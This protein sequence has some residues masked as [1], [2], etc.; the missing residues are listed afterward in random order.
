MFLS[1]KINKIDISKCII[2]HKTF[3]LITQT[4]TP[5]YIIMTFLYLSLVI[6]IV[7][8][9]TLVQIIKLLALDNNNDHHS[10]HT[11]IDIDITLRHSTYIRKLSTYLF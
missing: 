5:I 11:D 1:L 4:M 10:L 6:L 3:I 9:M 7:A 2:F 8:L